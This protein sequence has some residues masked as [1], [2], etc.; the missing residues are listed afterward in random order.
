[1]ISRWNHN[2]ETELGELSFFERPKSFL[3]DDFR[4][5]LIIPISENSPE[6]GHLIGYFR[7]IFWLKNEARIW[8]SARNNSMAVQNADYTYASNFTSITYTTYDRK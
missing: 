3:F 8:R 6:S 2:V 5:N 4:L 7:L 1:M